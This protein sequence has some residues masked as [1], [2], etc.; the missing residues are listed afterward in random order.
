[1]N[2]EFAVAVIYSVIGFIPYYLHAEQNHPQITFN[3]EAG[4]PPRYRSGESAEFRI[5]MPRIKDADETFVVSLLDDR[6]KRVLREE[7]KTLERQEFCISGGLTEPG[8]LRCQ[9]LLKK[10]GKTVFRPLVASAGFEVEK[11]LPG[12][13]PPSDLMEFWKAAKSRFDREVP[14]DYRMTLQRTSN[15]IRFYEVTSANYGGTRTY[16]YISIPEGD[17]KYPIL[18]Q[19]PPAGPGIW[20]PAGGKNRISVTVNVHHRRLSLENGRQDQAAYKELNTP[21]LYAYQGAPDRE[22]YYYY[23]SILGV[24]RILDY[25]T[26]LKEWDGKHLVMSGQSQGGA[27]ALI[28]AALHPDI[29]AVSAEIPALCDHRGSLPGWPRLLDTVNSA[30]EMSG[31]YDTA[32]FCRH[33][34]CPVIV[35]VGLIDSLCTPRSVHAAFNGIPAPDKKIYYGTFTGHGWG[36]RM[37]EFETERNVFLNKHLT[38][39]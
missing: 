15:G 11:I 38:M 36:D 23:K 2:R 6:G 33:I 32:N 26:G 13:P 5:R 3:R 16:A 35:A 17:G 12:A 39:E 20:R 7:F 8:F 14:P 21:L 10:N 27:F 28:M 31:Y 34:K 9:I 37:T 18:A 30:G 25:V 1:M 22:R 4:K 29:S 24:L 19:V